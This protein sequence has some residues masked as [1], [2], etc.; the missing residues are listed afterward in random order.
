MVGVVLGQQRFGLLPDGFDDVWWERGHG[1]PPSS[2]SVENSPDDGNIS[3]PFFMRRRSLLTEALSA[4]TPG[5]IDQLYGVPNPL[6]SALCV[7][8]PTDLGAQGKIRHKKPTGLCILAQDH[9][10]VINHL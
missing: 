4:H 7:H 9:P 8:I 2:G 6:G 1:Y 3:C 10:V 5:A